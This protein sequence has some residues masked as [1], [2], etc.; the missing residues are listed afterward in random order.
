MN[1]PGATRKWSRG[2]FLIS[3]MESSFSPHGCRECQRYDDFLEE[4][5]TARSLSFR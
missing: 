1:V 5:G 2:T 3:V 4:S